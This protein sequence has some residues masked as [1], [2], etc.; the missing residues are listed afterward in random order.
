MRNMYL[1]TLLLSFV[2]R[3]T[4]TDLYACYQEKKCVA[5]FYSSPSICLISLWL[6]QKAKQ[7]IISSVGKQAC[8][9]SWQKGCFRL[10]WLCE[11]LGR[12]FLSVLLVPQPSSLWSQVF[13]DSK[14]K[15]GNAG[16]YRCSGAPL[17][18]KLDG[19]NIDNP[20]LPMD[21][22]MTF[23]GWSAICKMFCSPF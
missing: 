4:H 10:R 16:Y 20:G 7:L 11:I 2:S 5:L 17:L 8:L 23:C 1:H 22:Y 3:C 13:L 21:G 9:L 15:A 19:F 12:W 18:Q 6:W 14:E